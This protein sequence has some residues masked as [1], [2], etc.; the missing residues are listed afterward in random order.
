[1]TGSSLSVTV[2]LKLHCA[3]SPAPSVT[4]NV[5]TVVP[6]GK[7]EPLGRPA[8]CIVVAPEQLSVPT[9]A[10]K[11]TTAP[12]VPASLLT[13]MFAGQLID[14]GVVSF[15]VTLKLHVAVSPAPSVTS[16]VLTVVPTGKV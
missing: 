2:T 16:N 8:I 5:L 1:M 15:T 6:T 14:G 9:G 12:Q 3:V 7:V 13:V 10:V 4:L 11:L